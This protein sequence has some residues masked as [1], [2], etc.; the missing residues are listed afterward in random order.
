MSEMILSCTT[1]AL[2][3]PG[4]DE[5][6]ETF[7]WAPKA[8]FKYWGVAGP[9]IWSLKEPRWFNYELCNKMAREA[10][11]LGLTE[12]YAPGINTSSPAAAEAH[13]EDLI[14]NF[15]LG[16]NLK[17]PLMV[18]S[19]GKRQPDGLENTIIGLKKLVP[20]I[21][22]MPIRLGLEPHFNS[23]LMTAEDFDAVFSEI[24]TPQIGITIDTGHFHA[25]KVDTMAFIKKYADRIYNVHL[26][27]H[28]GTQSVA[29][30]TGEIDLP[31][32][33]K[34]LHE[35]NYKGAIALELE[36]QDPENLP[37]YVA[38]AYTSLDSLIQAL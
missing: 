18:F 7:K 33:L 24:K 2:R 8:G 22:D 14:L 3:A 27:D 21:K 36:V 31:G 35:S 37:K 20:M 13:V 26:K 23:Q 19:G 38:E 6:L 16:V 32:I 29:I 5:I 25:A 30:G 1:C 28:I 17:S 34:L 15:E 11:L 10:G 9:I 4:K 12:V